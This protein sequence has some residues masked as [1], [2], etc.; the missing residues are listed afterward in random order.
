[1]NEW[2]HRLRDIARELDALSP[3]HGSRPLIT[4]SVDEW[5]V[6]LN[7]LIHQEEERRKREMNEQ[8]ELLSY[9]AAIRTSVDKHLKVRPM[10]HRPKTVAKRHIL[11]RLFNGKK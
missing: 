6:I 11:W 2:E 8:L 9:K 1:M 5:R 7:N 4:L 10:P 3:V